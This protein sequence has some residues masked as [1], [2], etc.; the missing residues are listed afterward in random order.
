MGQEWLG[1]RSSKN[2]GLKRAI[3][4]DISKVKKTD[5]KKKKEK[6]R[7]IIN[8]RGKMCK[9]KKR[10]YLNVHEDG[11]MGKWEGKVETQE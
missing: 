2:E 8:V 7:K 4:G 3:R 10:R 11:E 5:G 6:Q 1:N 9:M